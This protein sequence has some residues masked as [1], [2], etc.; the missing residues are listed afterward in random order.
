MEFLKKVW[1]FSFETKDV[2]NLVV[3]AI[4]YVLF[5]TVASILMG[6]LSSVPVVNVIFYV[7]GSLVD[8]YVLVGLVVLFLSYFKILK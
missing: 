7:L 6:V 1:P 4:L 5:L 2:T 8:V 3:K